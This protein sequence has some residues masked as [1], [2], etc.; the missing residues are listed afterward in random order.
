MHLE[1]IE[2]KEAVWIVIPAYNE[3]RVIGEVLQKLV[4][5]PYSVVVIDD[6]STDNTFQECLKY[7]VTVLHHTCN[8]G[9]GGALQT[10]ISYALRLPKT[11]YIVTFDSDG[12]HNADEIPRL[13]EPLRSGQYDVALGSR[14]LR[15]GDAVN[16]PATKKAMLSLATAFTKFT[17]HLELTD[18]HNGFRAFTTS[19]AAKINIT[20]NRMAHASE[21]L[22]QIARWKLRYCEVPV[23]ITYTDYSK[24]KG[25][26]L[27]NSVNI[28]WDM[29]RS[30][31]K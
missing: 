12:Q 28:L 7:P 18:T 29:M 23:T 3:G 1:N 10:G 16:I 4:H 31:L 27:L 22:Q 8:L 14:F 21:I 9:Q 26:S 6:N 24:V 5:L 17:S 11:R 20:Q 15:P 2:N 13:L 25:Q 30:N 19:A